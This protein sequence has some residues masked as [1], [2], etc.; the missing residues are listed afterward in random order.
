[1]G[2][3]RRTEDREEEDAEETDPTSLDCVEL[4]GA[5]NNDFG[6]RRDLGL[7]ALEAL[8]DMFN[9][10]GT[11]NRGTHVVPVSSL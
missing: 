6:R 2:L 1:M 7:D 3:I 5:G 10:T 8:D 11:S 4:R 9:V